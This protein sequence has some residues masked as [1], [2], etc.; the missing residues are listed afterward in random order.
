MKS[1]EHY[2]EIAKEEARHSNCEQTHWGAVL[3]NWKGEIIGLG[4]NHVPH[5]DLFR[6]CKPCIRRKIRSCEEVE[7]CAA[8]H[9][10]EDAILDVWRNGL[11]IEPDTDMYL[12]GYNEVEGIPDKPIIMRYYP[13][14]A[15]ARFILYH[16][17]IKRLWF[18]R[19][20][21]TTEE[22]KL[23]LP[24][25]RHEK[26]YNRPYLPD[27]ITGNQIWWHPGVYMGLE[28]TTLQHTVNGRLKL[29]K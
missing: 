24:F 3:V 17:N 7:K 9:A 18:Y 28:G 8:I 23:W 26:D 5:P 11:R 29:G 16:P 4:H 14:M 19:P 1:P 13:C 21:A 15:C 10:E 12:Y 25:P 27:F 2:L 6:Y 22:E 20:V